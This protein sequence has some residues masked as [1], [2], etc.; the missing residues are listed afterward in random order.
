MNIRGVLLALALLA[1][2]GLSASEL[3]LR[4][5]S[6][7]LGIPRR[8]QFINHASAVNSVERYIGFYNNQRLHSATGYITPV[9]K[10]QAMK[11]VAQIVFKIT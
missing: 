5:L 3:H 9:Q 2:Q 8:L 11:K 6:F 7:G 10:T 4:Q 1:S